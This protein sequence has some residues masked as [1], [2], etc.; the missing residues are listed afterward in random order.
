VTSDGRTLGHWAR[1]LLRPA[2]GAG[3][4]GTAGEVASRW[5][6]QVYEEALPDP[7]SSMSTTRCA[8]VSRLARVTSRTVT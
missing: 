8:I 4:E 6:S 2:H 5:F 3:T 1:E 7:W